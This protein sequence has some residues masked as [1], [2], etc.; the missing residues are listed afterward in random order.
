M[1]LRILKK[2][3]KRKKGI[4]IVLFLFILLATIF[5]A[6]SVNNILVVLNATDYCLE[7]GNV[8]DDTVWTVE[9]EYTINLDDWLE[10][11]GNRFI[12]DYD[13]NHGI[14]ISQENFSNEYEIKYSIT[15][16]PQWENHMTIFNQEMEVETVEPGYISMQ[17]REMSRN[18]LEPGDTLTF[19]FGDLTK[20]F[21]LTE[22]IIDPAFG[23]DFMG[24]TRYLISQKDYLDISSNENAR[25][26]NIYTITSDDVE[27]LSKEINQ[28]GVSVIVELERDL[29]SLQYT[30]TLITA[31]IL[32]LLGLCLIIIAFLILRFTIVFTLREDFTQIGIMKTIGIRNV[33]IKKLY[34]TKYFFIAIFA[35]AAGFFLSIPTSTLMLKSVAS[36]MMLEKGDA[37]I[38]INLICSICVLFIILVFCYFST[39]KIRKFS[40]IDA[41]RNG[42]TG[43]RFTK[44][45]GF[46]L[47]KH[48]KVSTILILI[49][50]EI[51]SNIKKYVVLILIFAMGNILIIL[52]LNTVTTMQSSEMVK[53]FALDITS[54]YFI[55]QNSIYSESVD[56]NKLSVLSNIDNLE[57]EFKTKGY[58]TKISSMI[59]YTTNIYPL[60]NLDEIDSYRALQLVGNEDAEYYLYEGELPALDNEVAMSEKVMED[61]DVNIGDYIMV[62]V[63][64]EYKQMLI[65]GSYQNYIQLGESILFNS[66][67]DTGNMIIASTW[68][69]Q[70]KITDGSKEKIVSDFPEYIFLNQDQVMEQQVGQ[71][72]SQ[73]DFV[74]NGILL[75]IC[76]INV[77]ITILM[78]KI[79]LVGEKSQLAVLRSLG[80]SIA[81]TR[82]ILTIRMGII[83]TMGI[84]SGSLLSFPLNKLVVRPLFGF[85]GATKVNIQVN[86]F[87]NYI[88][89]PFI[90]LLSVIIA[91]YVSSAQIKKLNL[92]EINNNE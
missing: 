51:L 68:Y 8:P 87:E 19:K 76:A 9:N 85:M 41:I 46:A 29:F 37:N 17:E 1:L 40:A 53:N 3:L 42:Q 6:S 21:I 84:I 12:K 14:Y 73:L 28:N 82:M 79:F 52:P 48:K 32:I 90:L 78:M 50:N 30:V 72:I 33:S 25:I 81:T 86:P 92:M 70:V 20:T 54:D 4:N 24:M 74:K 71:T 38:G 75:L 89:F 64:N 43:E 31:G 18:N 47:H 2:E 61:L 80:F 7:R 36:K 44:K 88:L 49:F 27:K 91:A 11:E 69:F 23:G 56:M 77:L 26:A 65:T 13:K 10:A 15:L 63:N 16:Q 62:N 45:R 22:P 39:N 67:L 83:L 60:G 66:S 58:N 55:D 5:V 57:S 35:V 59:M 34:L